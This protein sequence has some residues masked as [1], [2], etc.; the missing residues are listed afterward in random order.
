MTKRV[1]GRSD[2][3]CSKEL[4]KASLIRKPTG[5]VL[6]KEKFNDNSCQSRQQAIHK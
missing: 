3:M 1:N 4:C 5:Y 2:R 6:I